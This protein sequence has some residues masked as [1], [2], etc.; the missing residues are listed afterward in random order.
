[1]KRR[2]SFRW[3][4]LSALA[5]I[6]AG[7]SSSLFLILID[8]ATSARELRPGLIWFLPAAGFFIGW[9][10]HR[11]GRDIA[12]GTNLVLDEIHDP[13]KIIPV[14]MAPLILVTTVLTHLF[15]GSV[16][17]EGTAVQ[18][19]A[20]LA[21]Q[22]TRF[23][24]VSAEERRSLLVAGAG[25]G[26][27]AAI[28]A[29]WA[30]VVFGMELIEV[31]RLRVAAWL[32]CLIAAF[33]AYGVARLLGAPHSFLPPVTS[34]WFDGP[35]LLAAAAGGVLF[36][37]TARL[38]CRLTHAVEWGQERLISWSPLKP[39]LGGFLVLGLF[40]LL[41]TD[42][43]LGLGIPVIQQALQQA[44]PW[45]DPL[46]KGLFTVLSVGSG[47]KGGE[48]VPLVFMGTTLGSALA[49]AFALS[50]NALAASGFA[51][52]FA[53]AANTPIACT[54]MAIE[55]FGWPVAL[56]AAVACFMSYLC[57]GPEGL[58]RSQRTGPKHERLL[59]AFRRRR[60]F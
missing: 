42:R 55:I 33:V 45:T 3:I 16:G 2:F 43:Y 5:G 51:A 25:A 6:L 57:S 60:I 17:R 12:P 31:G 30:G 9:I 10:Y 46:W 56:P 38:F 26:F 52:V 47:F 49:G 44:A 53:G 19:S 14:R 20:S 27:S 18:M 39:M 37:L 15:G 40:L 4:L 54:L 29:P 50:G 21:D 35:T 11:Y 22:L 1:M 7:A 24:R 58:Y 59:A 13:K 32:E 36:G 48:F 41:G 34:S 28:G 23:F 8:A